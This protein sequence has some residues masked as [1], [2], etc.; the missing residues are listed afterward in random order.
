MNDDWYRQT[1]N[2]R[3]QFGASWSKSR[4]NETS[5]YQKLFFLHFFT[6]FIIVKQFHF[7]WTR[8]HLQLASKTNTT[9]Y[10]PAPEMF[11]RRLTKVTSAS[12]RSVRYMGGGHHAAPQGGLDGAVRKYLKEDHHVSLYYCQQ[13]VTQFLFC[14]SYLVYLVCIQVYTFCR[15][16]VLAR[17]SQVQ[18]LK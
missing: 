2:R 11:A 6:F 10:L 9:Y 3:Q 7:C 12:V 14:R 4:N 13:Y 16:L 5:K 17:S 15:R 18:L 1:Q 8:N